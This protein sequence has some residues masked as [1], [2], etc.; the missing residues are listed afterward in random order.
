M[1]DLKSRIH[2]TDYIFPIY[3][4]IRGS[5]KTKVISKKAAT[6]SFLLP[7]GQACVIYHQSVDGHIQRMFF[8]CEGALPAGIYSCHDVTESQ[9]PRQEVR[10]ILDVIVRDLLVLKRS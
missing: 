6:V 4:S 7:H 3:K 8:T 1:S 10:V 5:K 2:Y 9:V